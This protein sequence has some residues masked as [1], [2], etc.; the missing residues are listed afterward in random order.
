MTRTLPA[1][2]AAVVEALE[3]DGASVVS[4]AELAELVRQAGLH[5]DPYV[6]INRLAEH[7]WLLPSGVKGVWEFAPGA[8]AGAIGGGDPFLVLRAQLLASPGLDARV[9]LESAMWRHGQLDRAPNR[10]VVAVPDKT[11]APAALRR[12]F[13]VTSFEARLPAARAAGLPVQAPATLLVHLAHRPADVKNWGLVLGGLAEL[14]AEADHEKVLAELAGRPNT[15]RARLAYLTEPFAPNLAAAAR[16]EDR[17][18][19]WFGPR[20]P[21]RRHDSRWQIADTVLPRSPTEAAADG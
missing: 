8:R 21:L 10:H 20:G 2:L 7:G 11:T 16:P 19:V 6:V 17:G 12:A 18:V 1:G 5:T 15:T 14:I 9:G 4:A 3:L 13:Q